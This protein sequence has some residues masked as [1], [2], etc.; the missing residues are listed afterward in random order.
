MI[1][2]HPWTTGL[3]S[4]TSQTT[5]LLMLPLGTTVTAAQ[6]L[7][8]LSILTASSAAAVTVVRASIEE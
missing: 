8:N 6:F 1:L 7:L 5:V 4:G 3:H 2:I